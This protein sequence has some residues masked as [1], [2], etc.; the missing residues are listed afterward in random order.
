MRDKWKEHFER[1]RK[2]IYWKKHYIIED[3]CKYQN[4]S[5]NVA[6]PDVEQL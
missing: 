4:V 2:I 6:H 5:D 1:V 3:A